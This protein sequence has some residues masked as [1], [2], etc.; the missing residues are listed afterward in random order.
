MKNLL[1]KEFD[2]ALLK[3]A[4]ARAAVEDLTLREWVMAAIRR[5]LREPA[6]VKQVGKA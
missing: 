5:V 1:I 4:K 3:Q 6:V 2:E